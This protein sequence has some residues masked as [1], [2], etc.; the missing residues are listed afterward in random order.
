MPTTSRRSRPTLPLVRVDGLLARPFV[1]FAGAT[2][3]AGAAATSFTAGIIGHAVTLGGLAVL[4]ATAP[5]WLRG[6]AF[7]A[8][9]AW[10][11]AQDR[12]EHL[13][14]RFRDAMEVWTGGLDTWDPIRAA[15]V[16]V[17]SAIVTLALAALAIAFVE[18][19]RPTAGALGLIVTGGIAH[20]AGRVARRR[21]R[22]LSRGDAEP[23]LHI[24]AGHRF[25]GRDEDAV[26]RLEGRAEEAVERL[27]DRDR[28]EDPPG[29]T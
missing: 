2:T 20:Q 4:T 22:E 27:E 15:T 28:A 9:M 8:G 10:L 11:L 19:S 14:S 21:L 17:V 7:A 13:G 24:E 6:G 12:Y 3:V 16:A 23:A 18:V 5:T 1:G 29:S 26:A 25:S